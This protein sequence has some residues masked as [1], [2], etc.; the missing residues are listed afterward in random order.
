MN[1]RI[2]RARDIF[3]SALLMIGVVGQSSAEQLETTEWIIDVPNIPEGR[4]L[5]LTPSLGQSIFGQELL[6]YAIARPDG[7]SVY[8]QSLESNGAPIG[9]PFELSAYP[10]SANILAVDISQTTGEVVWRETRPTGG[11]IVAYGPLFPNPITLNPLETDLV[12]EPKINGR[13]VVWTGGGKVYFYDLA[14]A[15]ES[16]PTPVVLKDLTNTNRSVFQGPV[17]GERFV[18]WMECDKYGNDGCQILARD[19]VL[20]AAIDRIVATCADSFECNFPATSGSRIA[21]ARGTLTSIDIRVYDVATSL[22]TDVPDARSVGNFAMQGDLL[23]YR[24]RTNDEFQLRLY[25]FSD[26]E[27]FEVAHWPFLGFYPLHYLALHNDKIAYQQAYTFDTLSEINVVVSQFAFQCADQGGDADSDDICQFV[28]VCPAEDATGFDADSNGC[29]DSID[30]IP[31]FLNKL[32]EGTIIEATLRDKLLSRLATASA[33][34]DRD[35]ICAAVNQFESLK[36]QI[37]GLTGTKISVEA[38]D[39]VIAYIDNVI[40]LQLA[41]LPPGSTCP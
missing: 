4:T 8:I 41:A 20:G 37:T 7:S 28:D 17:I 6:A 3:I 22:T 23:F 38:A 19:H 9:V 39:L 13:K 16:D 21:W 29:I 35:N 5:A 34:L 18:V 1:L 32:V 25:R 24:R 11:Y 40:T 33:T 2:A 31:E 36:N 30:G 26:G 14:W 10:F 27:T 15:T 12:G